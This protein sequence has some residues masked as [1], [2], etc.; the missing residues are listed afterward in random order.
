MIYMMMGLPVSAIPL[1]KQN[2]YQG[3]CPDLFEAIEC[4]ERTFIEAHQASKMI[5]KEMSL[6][7]RIE[8]HSF[9]EALKTCHNMVCEDF[10][11]DINFGI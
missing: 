2:W 11:F 6:K 8:T 5:C 7:S 10:E 1:G 9:L 4:F 3:P